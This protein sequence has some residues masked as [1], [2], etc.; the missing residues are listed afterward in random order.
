VPGPRAKSPLF[1]SKNYPTKL[2]L[3]PAGAKR[4]VKSNQSFETRFPLE[5]ILF[6]WTEIAISPQLMITASFGGAPEAI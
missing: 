1:A 4:G 3:A 2:A 5:F 6:D